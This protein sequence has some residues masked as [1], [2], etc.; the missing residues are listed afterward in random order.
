MTREEINGMFCEAIEKVV[1][2]NEEEYAKHFQEK[3]LE[4]SNNGKTFSAM[5][6]MQFAYTQ[7]FA[8]SLDVMREVLFNALCKD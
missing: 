3:L 6:A 2:H 8:D 5:E 1:G 7:S 4:Y